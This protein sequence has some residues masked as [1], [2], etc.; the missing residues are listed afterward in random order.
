[1]SYN[2]SDDYQEFLA[3]DTTDTPSGFEVDNNTIVRDHK[4]NTTDIFC[5]LYYSVTG[6][7]PDSTWLNFSNNVIYNPAEKVLNGTYSYKYYDFPHDHNIYYDGTSDPVG[8]ALG[9]GDKIADPQ[10][11]NPGNL[12]YNLS[13]TS[14]AIDAAAS[15]GYTSDIYNNT[16]PYGSGP[17][18]GAIEYHGVATSE[19]VSDPGFENQTSST[20]S[21][22]WHSEGTATYGVDYRAGKARTGVNDAWISSNSSGQSGDIYQTITVSPNTTY[23][24]SAYVNSSA[25]IG[26]NFLIGMR[27]TSGGN[28]KQTQLTPSGTGYTQLVD[29]STYTTGASETSIV[30]FAGYTSTAKKA[31]WVQLDDFS[32]V[33]Q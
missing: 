12:N 2:I 20:L 8:Y 32:C 26:N 3:F 6:P 14:P 17:D 16:V 7:T 33:P 30:I 28:I 13:S 21:A 1:L 11:V 4:T 25:N 29:T 22:P 10:M 19:A 27:N 9:T 15:L 23:K 31:M 24:L 18:M 5:I